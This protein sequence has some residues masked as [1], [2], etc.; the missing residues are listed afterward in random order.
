MSRRLLVAALMF[1][2]I[3]AFGGTREAQAMC[4]FPA[5]LPA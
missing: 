4:G 2:V 3:L 1:F 5:V